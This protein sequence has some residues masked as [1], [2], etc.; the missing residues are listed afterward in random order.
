MNQDINRNPLVLFLIPAAMTAGILF[1]ICVILFLQSGSDSF[2]PENPDTSLVTL[3]SR[4]HGFLALVLIFLSHFIYTKVI[5]KIDKPNLQAYVNA[6]II[7]FAL[8]EA[9]ALIGLVVIFLAG[10]DGILQSNPAY[11]L[12]YLSSV[13]MVVE[14]V[15]FIPVLKRMVAVVT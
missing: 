2:A 4:I 13:Y 14:F 15:R 8:L 12:N 9:P 1:F 10:S 3:M 7:K 6:V 5:A 11:Y